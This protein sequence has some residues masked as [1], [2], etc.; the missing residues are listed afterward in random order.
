[1][2]RL[3][4]EVLGPLRVRQGERELD[5]GFP[6]QRALLALLLLHTGRP[7]RMHEIVDALWPE[8]PPLS[9]PNVVRR[10]AGS[11][12]RLLEPGLPPRAPGRRLLSRTGGYLL[13]ADRDE[14]DL[15]RFC[16]L[17][18]QGERAAAT[19]RPESAVR[20]FADAL[21][22]WRG[23]VAMGIPAATRAHV[24]FACVEREFVHTT[25]MAADAALLCDRAQDVLPALRRAAELDPLNEPLHAR[26]VRSLEG[27]GLRAEALDVYETVRRRLAAEL[28]VVP[29]PE[30]TAAHTRVLR[31]QAPARSRDE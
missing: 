5:L 23:R 22:L 31:R 10:Y 9:A 19:G 17:T 12:R 2:T 6:Q 28:S 13:E 14:V 24:Q 16:D 1:M 20:H 3:R 21:G 4:F 25:Q 8:Q 15:L 30:L 7:V 26:L 11:L 18:K 29:G 27:Q